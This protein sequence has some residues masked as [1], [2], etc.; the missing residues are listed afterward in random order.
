MNRPS[1][2]TDPGSRAW[3]VPALAS[4]LVVELGA[5]RPGML[6]SATEALAAAGV[7]ID[8]CAEIEGI[9]HLLVKNPEE[10]LGPLEQAGFSAR[11]EEVVVARFTDRPGALA[12]VLRRM[13]DAGLN[14]KFAYFGS[15]NRIVVG[16]GDPR[17]ALELLAGG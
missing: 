6:A 9:L 2:R 17:R 5:D 15:R 11:C 13:A 4:E 14:V 1:A 10:A 12:G 8:G 7:N 3:K 16:T